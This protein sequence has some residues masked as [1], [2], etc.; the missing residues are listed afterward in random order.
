MPDEEPVAEPY[1][2]PRPFER[3]DQALFFGR[4]HEAQQLVSLILSHPAVLFYAPSGAG[5]TSLL[6]ACVIPLLEGKAVEVLGPARVGGETHP[7]GPR[8]AVKNVFVFNALMSIQPDHAA[9]GHLSRQTLA[10]FLAERPYA[11]SKEE[12]LL[13]LRLLLFDQFEEIF[14]SNPERW[15]NRAGFFEEIGAALED[16]R[17]RAV[18]AMREEYIASLDPYMDRL[19][20]RLRTRYRLEPLREKA[21]LEAVEGPLESFH[22][23]FATGAAKALVDTLLH[24]AVK[25]LDGMAV[26]SAEFVDPLQLQVVCRRLWRS[27]PAKATEIDQA[28]IL[29]Y[30][31]LNKALEEYYDECIR[32]VV[33]NVDEEFLREWFEQELVT[34]EKTRS[35]VFRGRYDTAGL[36]NTVMDQLDEKLHLVHVEVRGGQRWYELIH[37]RL[38][39][40]IEASNKKWRQEM[41]LGDSD[42]EKW[43]ELRA[44]LRSSARKLSKEVKKP[45][46]AFFKY[47]ERT[48][49]TPEEVL[50]DYFHAE[51]IFALEVLEGSIHLRRLGPKSYGRLEQQWLSDVKRT[52]AYL[53]WEEQEPE[54]RHPDDYYFEAC[55]NL[56][57]GLIKEGLKASAQDF[58]ALEEYLKSRYLD[59]S[60]RFDPGKPDAHALLRR[61]AHRIY[62]VGS[63][64]GADIDW[65]HACDYAWLYY[66]NIIPAVKKQDEA[67]TLAVLKAFEFSR[68]P[69]NRYL[70]INCFE[71]ALAIYFL[72]PDAVRAIW[73]RA[74]G[75]PVPG[76]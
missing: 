19:P 61:K 34:S 59:E 58:S 7:E 39:E 69:E 25:T 22:R 55:R 15:K 21:A 53:L 74:E 30:A 65:S 60:G 67:S 4:E 18:F 64:A 16:P 1:V 76:F 63:G 75:Q 47:L 17:L 54:R 71:A 50:D 24:R 57:S 9:A 72:G 6:Q 42:V 31:D 32:A 62:E 8:E 29:G 27:L 51:L 44:H 33:A 23:T 43:I 40:P 3:G 38:I 5:K 36:P 14:T 26:A 10:E 13:S 70:I 11:E 48:D 28:H 46:R 66:D 52:K 20:E 73:E 68:A 12:G 35:L 37:D 56:R 49:S 41:R 2:G 45:P